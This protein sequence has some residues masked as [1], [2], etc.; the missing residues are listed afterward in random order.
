M[1]T[2][3]DWFGRLERL[4]VKSSLTPAEMVTRDNLVQAHLPELLRVVQKGK[5]LA[6]R[7]GVIRDAVEHELNEE[8]PF[9]EGHVL[10]HQ[11]V[12]ELVLSGLIEAHAKAL[13]D[14]GLEE[15]STMQLAAAA[16]RGKHV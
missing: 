16:L 6:L 12:E 8:A 1:D 7:L 11:L 4:A 3:K 14:L 13:G 9:R 2:P 15:P 5:L 10:S